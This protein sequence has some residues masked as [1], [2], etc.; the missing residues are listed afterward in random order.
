MNAAS[1]ESLN[2][3]LA[4]IAIL[5]SVFALSLG[6]ALIKAT[7]T[8]LPIWQMILLR[9]AIALP[10]LIIIKIIRTTENSIYSLLWVVLRS[11]LLFLMWLCY[12]SALSYMP[13]SLAAAAY[14]TSPLFITLMV[15][16]LSGKLPAPQ[17]WLAVF[18]G[19]GGV[20]LILRPEASD[21]RLVTL[22]PVF[23]AFLYA[24]AMMMTS[25]KLSSSDPVSLAIALNV[26]FIIGGGVI[27]LYAGA[28]GNLLFGPWVPV[29]AALFGVMVLLA[30]AIIVGSVAAAIAYQKGPPAIIAAFDYSYLVFSLI[31]GVLFFSEIPQWISM[32]GIGAI[33]ISGILALRNKTA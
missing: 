1:S 33:A 21:F 14:Y 12:Y 25:S 5:A 15:S 27:G 7:G 32:L 17:I 3:R 16:L 23:A 28:S 29:D 2:V 9:S 26:A 19:F 22:L 11:G 20:L 10:V 30:A 6:D 13:F 8:S 31:W 4:I 24:A 18:L